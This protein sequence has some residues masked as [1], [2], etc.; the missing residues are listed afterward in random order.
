ML[1]GSEVWHFL[2]IFISSAD[3]VWSEIID[4][5][6]LDLLYARIHIGSIMPVF[7]DSRIMSIDPITKDI[8]FI[9]YYGK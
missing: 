6:M 7:R 1:F 2:S 4:C 5:P 3:T 9:R 8:S